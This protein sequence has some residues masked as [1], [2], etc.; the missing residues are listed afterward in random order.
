MWHYSPGSFIV[1]FPIVRLTVSFSLDL[2]AHW[3]LCLLIHGGC[4]RSGVCPVVLLPSLQHWDP[5]SRPL[6]LEKLPGGNRLQQEVCQACLHA[7]SLQFCHGAAVPSLWLFFQKGEEGASLTLVA[8][9]DGGQ[10]LNRSEKD[11]DLSPGFTFL[12]L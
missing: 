12:L 2:C 9:L 8:Y 11:V 6:A 5:N 4:L 10:T 3:D 1:A 7:C